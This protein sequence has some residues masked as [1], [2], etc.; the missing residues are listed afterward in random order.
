MAEN[1]YREQ[2]LDR[3]R[4]TLE[5][6]VSIRTVKRKILSSINE[7]KE[8][9][10]P[11]FPIICMTGGLPVPK[12]R[13][14]VTLKESGQS[15]KVRSVLSIE[16]RTYGINRTDPDTEISTLADDLWKKLYADPTVG[17]LAESVIV[18]PNP[19]IMF[20]EPF[21]R[22]DM[23]YDVEYIHDTDNI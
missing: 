22:F 11:Q 3:V 4:I 7:L 23:I 9:A 8:I 10:F 17:G 18:K 1:S 13:G 5:A 14:Y 20:L 21:F 12:D 19:R 15:S 16:L 2:I 6:I